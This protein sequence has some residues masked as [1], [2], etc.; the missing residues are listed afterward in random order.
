MNKTVLCIGPYNKPSNAFIRTL[1][2]EKLG[3]KVLRINTEDNL[4][5]SNLLFRLTKK[6]LLKPLFRKILV[7]RINVKIN[8]YAPDLV[9]V[10]KGIDFNSSDLSGFKK[11]LPLNS[12]IVHLNPDD[13][14]GTFQDGWSRFVSAIPHYDAHFIPKELNRVDYLE[15]SAKLVHVYDRSFDPNYHRPIRLSKS[16]YAKYNCDIGFI[17]TYADQRESV[18]YEMVCA[19]LN[20]SLWGDHWSQGRYWRTLKKYWRGGT[21]TGDNYIKAIC[22]MKIALHFIRHENRDLQDSRTFEIPACGSFMLAERT[23]DHEKLFLENK[24]VVLFNSP[25][26]CIEKCIYYL[27]NNELRNQIAKAGKQRVLNSNYDYTSR[28]KGMLEVLSL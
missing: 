19:G 20:V 21:Q 27:E 16:D 28:L 4:G 9:F 14:F 7:S 6:I 10:E 2:F 8:K 23:K 25:S 13:P 1:S 26:D 3:H 24:E 17:G 22:G 11:A 12:K 5:V 15:K 18:I